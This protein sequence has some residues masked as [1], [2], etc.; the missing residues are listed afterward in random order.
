MRFVDEGAMK[1]MKRIVKNGWHRICGYDVY[2]VDGCV[3]RG[4]LG[5]EFN[6][7]TAYPYRVCKTGGLDNCYGISVE[8]FRSGCRRGTVC[9]N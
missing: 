6:L 9:M 4:I 3:V 8:A 7:R 1:S 2:V 5:E